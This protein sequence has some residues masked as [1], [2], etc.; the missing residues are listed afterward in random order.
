MMKNKYFPTALALYINYF[1]QGIQAIIISQNINN[2]AEQWGTT[3][4]QVMG[5][6][7]ATGIGKIII[8]FISGPLSDKF[9]RKPIVMIGILGY[10][11]FFSGLLWSTSLTMAYVVAFSAGAATSFLDGASYPALMEI[12][13]DNPS[14]A[15][16]IVKG[17]IAAAGLSPMF[18]AFL[19]EG[20]Y[21]FG[22]SVVIP[23]ALVILNLVFM[24]TRKFP[25][26]VEKTEA[27]EQEAAQENEFLEKPK[28]AVE[29]VLLMAFAFFIFATFYLWQQTSSLYAIEVVGMSEVAARGI[30]SIYSV[31]SILAVLFSSFIM[32]KGIKDITV[33]VVYTLISSIVLAIVYVAPSQ[34]TLSVGA[35]VVGFFAAGGI[36]QI[37]N[38]MLSQFFPKGKGKNTSIYNIFMASAAYAVPVATK[39]LMEIDFT[40]ILLL[41]VAVSTICFVIT[42]VLM[43]RYRKVFGSKITALIKKTA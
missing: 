4:A 34:L 21:W 32:S 42:L 8:L 7:A 43:I 29:G 10:V 24:F 30:M 39:Y 38:A 26:T 27:S 36:M 16:V 9:G 3:T 23:L 14:I 1:V 13:P 15:S 19:N 11:F 12:Y 6:I 37:G 31:G 17:F 35:F 25:E 18:I 5:V 28:Y 33:M 40:K 41:N 20:G 22:W 2:F